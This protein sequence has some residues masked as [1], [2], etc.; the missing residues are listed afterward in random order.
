MPRSHILAAVCVLALGAGNALAAADSPDASP[1]KIGATVGNLRF[2]DIRYLTR[3]LDDLKGKKAYVLVFTT[4][5]CPIVQRYMPRIKKLDEEYRGKGIQ[6]VALNVGGDDMVQDVAQHAI[7]FGMEFPF[8]KDIEGSCAKALGVK[9]VP[10]V[11][12]LDAERKLVY[13]GRIDDQLRLGGARPSVTSDDLKNAIEDVLAGRQVAKAETPVDGCAITFP[14]P[15]KPNKNLTFNQHIAPLLQK[16]CQ[17]CHHAGGDAAPFALMSYEDVTAQAEMIAETVSDM[18]MPPWYAHYKQPFFNKRGLSPEERL[19]VLQWV[20]AGMPK[21]DP[22]TAPP[23]KSF[24]STKWSFGE[25]DL[26]IT[27]PQVHE[28]PAEGFVD[29]KYVVMPYV[30]LQDTWIC[31]AEILPDNPVVVHHCNMAYAGL[32]G[33]YS[34]ANFITGRVPGGTAFTTDEGMAFKIPKNSLIGLQIHYTTTGKKEKNQMRVGLKFPRYVVEREVKPLIVTN[35]KIKIPP[36]ASS[37][38]IKGVKTIP[39]DALG[40]GMFSHMHLRGKD[41]TFVAHYPNGSTE[42]LLGIPNYNY[43]WQQNYRWEPKTKKFPAGTKIEVMAHF[44]NSAFN[45][46]NPDPTATVPHGPQ[47]IHEMMFGFFFYA[48]ENE[49]LGLK[50]DPKNGHVIGKSQDGLAAK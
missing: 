3:S 43:E 47:T 28:L 36:G 39:V 22:A 48:A 7:D 9:R 37:H 5:T 31:G 41:M 15:I 26:V 32:G 27:A 18:R 45:P 13:R 30:F 23:A 42:T 12:V 25:P 34:D 11:A 49:R 35:G 16:H 1:A 44:D 33:K 6:F 29:Y 50:I 38:P 10:E 20:K 2:K 17:E 19:T 8:V 14:E 24:S 21:G 40:I 46:F 4:T